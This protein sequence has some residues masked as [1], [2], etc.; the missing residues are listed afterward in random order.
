MCTAGTDIVSFGLRPIPSEHV[1][2][3]CADWAN[4][5]AFNV[6]CAPQCNRSPPQN[7]ERDRRTDATIVLHTPVWP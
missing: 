6:P 3:L 7:L 4:V 1:C 5:D 2:A